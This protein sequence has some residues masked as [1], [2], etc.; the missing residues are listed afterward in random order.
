MKA[1]LQLKL[2]QSLTMTPQ[3]QQAIRLLQLSSVE[4]QLEIQ[5]A[6]ESNMMLELE[7]G[8]ETEDENQT[9]PVDTKSSSIDVSTDRDVEN[10]PDELPVDS[11][12]DDIYDG[13]L[14]YS[15]VSG[16]GESTFYENQDIEEKSLHNHLLWQLNLTQ[17]SDKDRAIA[18]A[19]I[20]ALDDDGYLTCSLDEIAESVGGEI[21]SETDEIEA[22]LHLIQS[23]DPA[24]VGARDLGEC[25][26]LQL[27]QLDEDTTYLDK[28][29]ELVGKHLQVMG[30]RDFNQLMRK[31]KVNQDDLQQ[32]IALIQS[33]SPRP[34][35]SIQNTKTEYIVPDVYVRK[36]KGV[37]KVELNTDV[38]PQL[39]INS[40]YASMIRRADNS[41][42]NTSLKS[43]LQEARWFIKSLQS[44]SE[45]LLRVA[46]TIVEKQ[47]AF[48]EHGE[49]AMKPMVLHDIAE[50]LG[51]HE[52]T[53]SRVT[54][55]KYMHTPRG[56]YELKYFFSSQVSTDEGGS[57]SSTA[58]RA[59]IK[60][61]INEEPH[62][63]PLS[64]SKIADILSSQGIRV[65]RRTVAKYR[66]AMA[67]P[68]SN[69]RKRL[70]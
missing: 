18:V 24:G 14:S 54:T 61:L 65:A 44:R 59:L 25:L 53:I 33:L 1:S 62:K 9:T 11:Q 15:T 22:V 13:G 5:Q 37:W 46:S 39:R 32:I 70:V 63:K 48:L 41:A 56:I 8:D 69:E 21:D 30:A 2:G 52:S 36:E 34:G 67:I 6:L 45:T 42:D 60:K 43:H 23:L 3:L 35:S 10:I 40:T 17:T 66:E 4:L 19:I 55:R 68:P 26:L 16:D 51:L 49:E 12:W 57:A 28:A 58:I 27:E 7:E 64:D 47:R 31:L 20:D 50:L 38:I 29:K